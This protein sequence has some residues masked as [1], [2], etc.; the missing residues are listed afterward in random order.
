MN[1]VSLREHVKIFVVAV[2]VLLAVLPTESNGATTRYSNLADFQAAAG[3][4]VTI[5]F[6]TGDNGQP[7]APLGG[8]QSYGFSGLT[9]GGVHFSATDGYLVAANYPPPFLYGSSTISPTSYLQ[10]DL[11]VGTTAV[12]VSIGD[13]VTYDPVPTFEVTLSTGETFTAG[14]GFFGVVSTVPI[15]WIRFRFA[16][17]VQSGYSSDAV[18]LNNFSYHAVPLPSVFPI[19]IDPQLY[20]GRYMIGGP[21]G[22]L[23]FFNGP[24]TLNLAPGNYFAGLAG[25][26]ISQG[27]ANGAGYFLFTVNSSGQVVNVLNAVT[28]GPSGAAY[29]SGNTIVLNNATITVNPQAY[30]GNYVLGSHY[31]PNFTRYVGP[32]DIVLIP[33]LFQVI[34]TAFD[35]YLPAGAEG[36]KY[37]VFTIDASGQIANVF[38]AITLGP[39]GAVVASGSTLTFN[40]VTITVEPNAYAGRYTLSSHYYPNF[41]SFQGRQNIVVIPELLNDLDNMGGFNAFTVNGIQAAT[42]FA[43][44]VNASGVITG[45]IDLEHYLAHT[46]GASMATANGSVLSLKTVYVRVDP[47]TYAQV[48]RVGGYVTNT[49]I[50]TIPLIPGLAAGL[51]ANNVGDVFIPDAA[52]V[53]PSSLVLNIQGQPYTFLFSPVAARPVANAGS[54][55]S[56]NEGATVT[57]DGTG[58]TGENL[59][60]QWTQ[61]AG[62]AALISDDTS[63]TPTVTTPTL[64]GGFGSQVLA[65]KLTVT[66]FGQSDSANVNVT[67][68]NVNHAPEAQPGGDQNVDE[69][70]LVRLNGGFSFDPDGDPI[71]Y[72][73]TQTGGPVATLGADPT[74]PENSSKAAFIAPTIAGGLAGAQTLTF[75]LAVSDGG[76]SSAASVNV[77]VEN[78]NHAPTANAGSSQTV[79]PGTTVYLT[80]SGDDPDWDQISYQWTQMG[81][82]SVSLAN[83]G[84]ATANFVAPPVSG[85][86]DLT[87]RL[88]VSDSL[89]STSSDV[90]IT[91]KNGA[92]VCY[93]ARAVPD[94]LWPPNHGLVSVGISGVTDPD[95][96]SVVIN[97]NGVTQDEQVSGLGDGDTS[98]DAVIQSNR[99]SLRAE[100]AGNGNGRVY[101]VL[102]TADDGNGGICVGSV[103]VGVPRDMKPGNAAIDSGQIYNSTQP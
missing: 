39:S 22:N 87:F 38:N 26:I 68:V 95:D 3:S 25:E 55:Q 63:P 77:V 64:A 2:V 44:A 60:Y 45:V 92:P 86:T 73:W 51:V 37:A 100:R 58:S 65:F 29:A 8:Q 93:A 33:E 81:G 61:I 80:G 52:A 76:L 41:V 4:L 57:L 88:T 6:A 53:N 74:D 97:I 71:T 82:P 78:V 20:T 85:T 24:K 31:F 23:G 72:Q 13:L 15:E 9:V 16:S 83:P 94:V 102:F 47:T 18:V 50:V 89:L 7:L 70:A 48:Y 32:K 79:H 99:A 62:P 30:T 75:Q 14:P 17:Q 54:N 49:G 96:G 35:Y 21:S 43:F 12:G 1:Y 27:G 84:A 67:V 28:H 66:S 5:D 11:P 103:S 19:N 101:R 91:V 42:E 40:N 36:A 59:S 46:I 98:P 90:V 10:A 69:G 34:G 56:A